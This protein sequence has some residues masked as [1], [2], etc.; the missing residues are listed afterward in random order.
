MQSEAG[1]VGDNYRH[2]MGQMAGASSDSLH[3]LN[4][5]LGLGLNGVGG[6]TNLLILGFLDTAFGIPPFS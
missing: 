4:L 3:P 6:E 2:R 5:Q 1:Q